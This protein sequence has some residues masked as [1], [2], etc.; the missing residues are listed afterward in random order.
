MLADWT[1][2]LENGNVPASLQ[3]DVLEAATASTNKTLVP[4][5]KKYQAAKAKGDLVAQNIEALEGGDAFEG[6]FIFKSGQC[7]QCHIVNNSGGSIGPDLSHVASRLPRLKL[8]ES[9]LNPQAEIAAGYATISVTNKD[10]DTLTG[11]V[12]SETPSEL[13]LKDA[14]GQLLKIKMAEIDSRTAPTTAMPVMT[15]VLK[16]REIRDVVEYLSTLR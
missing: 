15:E 16:P 6:E 2:R 11:T 7:T 5:L 9:I 4:K 13:T 1:D 3:L 10:G 14:D 8:L 12:Q